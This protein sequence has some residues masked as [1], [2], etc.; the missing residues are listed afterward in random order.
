MT[1]STQRGR[2]PRRSGV[3]AASAVSLALGAFSVV[4]PGPLASAQESLTG[5]IRGADGS[6]V[7][8]TGKQLESDLD[9]GSCLVM[10]ETGSRKGSQ[11]GFSWD[12]LEPSNAT[13]NTRT[14]GVSVAFDNS[15]DRTFAYWEWSSAS[16]N[17]AP[18]TLG[19]V[20]AAPA[21]EPLGTDV[22]ASDR[23]N[24][25][26]EIT[27]GP[28]ITYGLKSALSEAE[29]EKFAQAGADSRVRYVWKDQYTRDKNF[30]SRLQATT[31]SFFIALVN[32]WPNENNECNPIKV[33]WDSIQQHV[34]VPGEETK[35]GHIDV[36][37]LSDGSYQ[38]RPH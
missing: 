25:K 31:N 13:T 29:V 15:Q 24:E 34:I 1:N 14:W 26:L 38:G 4:G 17:T 28:Q 23:A 9:A 3:A 20:P 32:P 6:K 16:L 5:G 10:S 35:V 37:E 36:P 11:A 19:S 22:A 7:I 27:D 18:V 21:G 30:N 12:R 2:K 8:N 33:D